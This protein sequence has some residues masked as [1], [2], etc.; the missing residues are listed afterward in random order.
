MSNVSSENVVVDFSNNVVIM[1]DIKKRRLRR[2]L[3]ERVD[4]SVCRV[5]SAKRMNCIH[6]AT[7]F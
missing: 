5:F 1:V 7:V 6:E 3:K 4:F 2:K